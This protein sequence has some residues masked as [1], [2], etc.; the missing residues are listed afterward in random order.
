MPQ[1]LTPLPLLTSRLPR[2]T[3]EAIG[4]T[5]A[6]DYTDVMKLIEENRRKNEAKRAAQSAKNAEIEAAFE[7][8]QGGP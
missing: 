7:Q 3:G 4:N 6:D 2:Y 5:G 1:L 8:N